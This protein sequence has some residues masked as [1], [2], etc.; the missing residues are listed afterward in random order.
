[1]K[2]GTTPNLVKPTLKPQTRFSARPRPGKMGEI[3]C[4]MVT[5]P[6]YISERDRFNRNTQTTIASEDKR[7]KLRTRENNIRKTKLLIDSAQQDFYWKSYMIDEKRDNS[8]LHRSKMKYDYEKKVM[9][10][11]KIIE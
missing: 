8:L 11:N 5:S 9:L 10:H 4:P 1:M 6:T 3:L 2:F 7:K